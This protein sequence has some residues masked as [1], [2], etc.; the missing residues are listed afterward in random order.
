[1]VP[2]YPAEEMTKIHR[3]ETAEGANVK[4]IYSSGFVV[5]PG[6]YEHY[7]GKGFYKGNLSIAA[8]DYLS[9][10]IKLRILQYDGSEKTVEFP[11]GPKKQSKIRHPKK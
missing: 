7:I 4:E 3:I 9:G 10:A 5:K 1:M 8:G 2:L 6:S 11:I